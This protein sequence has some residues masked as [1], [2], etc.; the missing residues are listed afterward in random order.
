MLTMSENYGW[1]TRF[2]CEKDGLLGTSLMKPKICF[3]STMLPKTPVLAN[4]GT[5]E[6]HGKKAKKA[7]KKLAS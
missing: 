6:V 4:L 1:L 3:L 2:H 5:D 7:K